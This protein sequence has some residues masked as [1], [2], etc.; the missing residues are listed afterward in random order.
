MKLFHPT[1][2][3]GLVVLLV[4]QC[5]PANGYYFAADDGDELA[6]LE[7]TPGVAIVYPR[8]M[9][10]EKIEVE[11]DTKD[12]KSED[13][14]AATTTVAP[15]TTDSNISEAATTTQAP[16]TTEPSSTTTSESSSSESSSTTTAAPSTVASVEANLPFGVRASASA[17][18]GS[19][20]NRLWHF[21][22]QGLN[23]NSVWFSPASRASP[24]QG[25]TLDSVESSQSAVRVPAES[26]A[27]STSTSS[28]SA[29][30]F[31]RRQPILA[32]DNDDLEGANS[33]T[34][35]IGAPTAR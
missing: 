5:Y 10:P 7:S 12:V 25:A 11:N 15:T 26:A 23:T 34:K 9:G 21:N 20:V 6:T 13:S 1:L 3:L 2:V 28:A 19:N 24:S 8:A 29:P 16:T 30:V 35:R 31:F 17:S 18:T 27:A 14:A 32:D 22:S 4:A 33:L